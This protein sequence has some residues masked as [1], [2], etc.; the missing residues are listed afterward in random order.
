MKKKDEVKDEKTV[1]TEVKAEV[2][3]EAPKT[4]WGKNAK[5]VP[6][7]PQ[8]QSA[9]SS[10]K[11][12]PAEPPAERGRPETRSSKHARS[13]SPKRPAV[14]KARAPRDEERKEWRKDNPTGDNWK[15]LDPT[16]LPDQ[17]LDQLFG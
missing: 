2:L 10:G 9:S 7:P 16:E 15:D 4:K 1:K 17:K 13:R 3:T 14:L 6:P 12:P 8:N 5:P 11:A